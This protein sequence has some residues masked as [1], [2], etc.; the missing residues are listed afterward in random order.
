M[1][2][3][4]GEDPSLAHRQWLELNK[5]L[6][7]WCSSEERQGAQ[8]KQK[9]PVQ[10]SSHFLIFFS[11]FSSFRICR[12][13]IS[14]QLQVTL[15]QG[16]TC[17]MC[18]QQSCRA[19]SSTLKLPTRYFY[20][21]STSSASES[22]VVSVRGCLLAWQEAG[23]CTSLP[24]RVCDSQCCCLPASIQSIWVWFML[25]FDFVFFFFP[26]AGLYKFSISNLQII[27]LKE[28]STCLVSLPGAREGDMH[29]TASLSLGF[30]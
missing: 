28:L 20:M 2:W 11:C 30:A 5:L 10:E 14:R 29:R 12:M 6:G 19:N 22:D 17:L 27:V 8:S 16:S 9:N 4:W 3:V 18:V 21:K 15:Q 7:S 1:V 26:A 13:N 24:A 25:C 23:T